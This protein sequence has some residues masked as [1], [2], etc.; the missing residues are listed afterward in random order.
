MKPVQFAQPSYV[1]HF[2]IGCMLQTG[3]GLILH[4]SADSLKIK[5]L[6]NSFRVVIRVSNCLDSE[7]A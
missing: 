6:K 5:F 7:Q 3:F 2:L 4:A 1:V